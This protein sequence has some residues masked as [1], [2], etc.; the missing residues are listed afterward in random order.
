[1]KT[2]LCHI[3]Y[4]QKN[5]KRK[6]YLTQ[7]ESNDKA[8]WGAHSLRLSIPVPQEWRPGVRADESSLPR[9]MMI[10]LI[11][12]YFFRI[13]V[14]VCCAFQ[15]M[16][17]HRWT[18]IKTEL[19][20]ISLKRASLRVFLC[21]LLWVVLWS[22]FFGWFVISFFPKVVHSYSFRMAYDRFRSS[23]EALIIIML[24]FLPALFFSFV[25]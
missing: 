1:M 21:I 6:S 3:C 22:A 13:I 9:W 15:L 2:F 17:S 12:W 18:I 5:K 23:T 8:N 11:L 24:L 25:I 19:Y 10:N 20:R 14:I 7:E 16:H 4:S